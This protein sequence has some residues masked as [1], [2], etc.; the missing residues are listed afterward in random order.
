MISVIIP[1]YNRKELMLQAVE[2]VL[3]QT[4]YRSEYEIIVVKNYKDYDKL[5]KEKGV[6]TFYIENSWFSAKLSKGIEESQGDIICF[7][8]DDDLFKSTKLERVKSIFEEYNI[9]WY[10]NILIAQDLQGNALDYT[11][12]YM[13]SV[14]KYFNNINLIDKKT[15]L[16]I[17]KIDAY[18]T[19]A[20]NTSTHCVRRDIAFSFKDKIVKA[21]RN[22]DELIFFFSVKFGNLFYIDK[23]PLTIYRL[24]T[25]NISYYDVKNNLTRHASELYKGYKSYEMIMEYF[26]DDLELVQIVKN[27]YFRYLLL[28]R[29][30]D[31]FGTE[32][33]SVD[34]IINKLISDVTILGLDKSLF[35]LVTIAVLPS[36]IRKSIIKLKLRF[37]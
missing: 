34:E 3:H 24:H 25:N 27:V 7:L 18:L 19:L 35:R 37:T 26:I 13:S 12:S 30:Y 4:L 21:E 17:K 10:K 15:L 6:R 20:A 33:I 5:L 31:V 28:A 23:E 16:K 11:Y 32:K 36:F 22:I 2:S 9:S 29:I 1:S 14:L 8:D